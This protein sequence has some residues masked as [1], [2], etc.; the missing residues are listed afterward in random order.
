MIVSLID[1]KQSNNHKPISNNESSSTT[2]DSFPNTIS[3]EEIKFTNILT[4][5]CRLINKYEPI[6]LSLFSCHCNNIKGNLHIT[7]AHLYLEPIFTATGWFQ[8][9]TNKN[10]QSQD[11]EI[12]LKLKLITEL[13]IINETG[14]IICQVSLYCVFVSFVS[15]IFV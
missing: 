6:L 1:V 10:E 7:A 9:Q 13:N 2:I 15:L 4:T 11:T 3:E 5:K 8:K 12:I 14:E